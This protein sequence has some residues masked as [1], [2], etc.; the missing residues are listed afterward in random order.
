MTRTDETND[1]RQNDL[2]HL[3][4][5]SHL[6]HNALAAP[7]TQ[8]EIEMNAIKASEEEMRTSLEKREPRSILHGMKSVIGGKS[9]V[10]MKWSDE[11][12][13]ALEEMKKGGKAVVRL[14]RVVFASSISFLCH[15]LSSFQL[16]FR[17]SSPTRAG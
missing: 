5:L 15:S 11:A 17:E 10:G 16:I 12:G 1:R 13:Q 4:Y 14:V 6:R 8:R 2:N 3:S 7:L 9:V